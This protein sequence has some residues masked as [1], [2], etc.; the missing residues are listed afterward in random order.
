M[1]C[2]QCGSPARG[3]LCWHLR[4]LGSSEAPCQHTPENIYRDEWSAWRIGSFAVI[5]LIAFGVWLFR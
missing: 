2:P 4:P 3:Q 5:A 1:M